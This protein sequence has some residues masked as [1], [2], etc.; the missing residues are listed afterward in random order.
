MKK[1]LSILTIASC[2]VAFS[3]CSDFLDQTSESEQTT[4]NTFNSEYYTGQVINKIYGDL[5]QDRTYSQDFA[6]IYC[7]NSDIELVDGLGND[8]TNSASERGNMNYNASSGWS[9]LSGS[10]DAMF[11]A[12]EDC[13]L[14][15][16]GIRNSN[17]ISSN[18][19]MKEYLGE[20]LTLRA[21]LYLDIIRVWGDVPMKFEATKTDL[22]NAYAGKTNRDVI[23][24]SL[25]TQ[26]DEAIE[27]LPWAGTDSYT[28]EHITK[29]Y[30]HALY[31]QIA[32]TLG[33]WNIR[34]KDL[35]S[36][37]ETASYSDPTYPTQRKTNY[38]S[39][40]QK[41]LPHLAAII[42][43]GIHNLNP[44]FQNEWYLN[45]QLSLDKTYRENLFEIPMLQNVSGEL[46]Y[47]VGVRLNGITSTYG[48]G[49]SSGKMKLTAPF[50]YSF[51]DSDARRDITCSQITIAEGK[52]AKTNTAAT[53]VTF[54]G[55]TPFGIYIGKWDPRNENAS[56][57]AQNLA[58]SAK[59]M[60]G[61]NVIKMRMS[62]VYLMYA[63]V[64]NELYGPTIAGN[65]A[66]N[67][68]TA[69]DA[70]EK[71]HMRAY[72]DANSDSKQKEITYL[73]NAATSKTAFFNA[74]VDEEGWEL[75]GEGQRKYD[76]IR[77]NLLVEKTKQMKTNY[78]TAIAQGNY[79][80]TVYFNYTDN[81]TQLTIN[82]K[83]FT[84]NGLQS[85]QKETDYAAN[86]SGFGKSKLSSSSD[87]QIYTNLPSIS[88]GLLGTASVSSDGTITYGTPTVIN[89]YLMPISSTTISNSHNMLQN[90]YGFSN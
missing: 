4:E 68:L 37:Y 62:Q 19:Q 74:L 61:I 44:S 48:Y 34:E 50:F 47:T 78:L 67:G 66:A 77:W 2:A 17:L 27:L 53:A 3:S 76:L 58:A 7:L 63:E 43:S 85:G 25:L 22:S 10:W 21:M 79:P 35:G 6:F 81:Q 55:N 56:W 83:S 24:D 60:T 30:A 72:N 15:I 88:S 39:Y 51:R 5:T 70:L 75:A 59:H 33:G 23:M 42:S 32:L 45:N 36:D 28:T 80:E 38:E 8:A 90:S 31:A 40:Y 12:V 29:G 71:V 16:E 11:G 46:G 86:G 14:A 49:N 57:L 69:L 20:A 87:T 65:G 9:K 18:K 54:N 64:M 82:E 89:R 52:N 84:W 73:N 1:I 41:A 13:N 26:L